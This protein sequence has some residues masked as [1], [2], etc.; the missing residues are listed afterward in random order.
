[1]RRRIEKHRIQRPKDWKTVET[2]L[3]VDQAIL[4]QRNKVDTILVDCM[5]L[6]LSNLMSLH[7]PDIPGEQELCIKILTNQLDKI[8]SASAKFG[9][10]VIFVSNETGHGIVPKNSLGRFYIDLSGLM[11][12]VLANSCDHVIKMEVGIPVEIK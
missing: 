2:L 9:G 12:Q 1:M 5:T 6:Y 8:I 10:D 7:D 11:N 4:D 3:H